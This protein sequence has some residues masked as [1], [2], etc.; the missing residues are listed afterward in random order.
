MIRG[1]MKFIKGIIIMMTIC[2]IMYGCGNKIEEDKINVLFPMEL[3]NNEQELVKLLD[4]SESTVLLNSSFDDNFN[5]CEIIVESYQDGD[6]IKVENAFTF[7]VK[8]SLDLAITMCDV[9]NWDI[10]A[11]SGDTIVS[12]SI[13]AVGESIIDDGMLKAWSYLNYQVDLKLHEPQIIGINYIDDGSTIGHR[14]S[15]Y[16][17]NSIANMYQY[18]YL[19]IL[20]V[21]FE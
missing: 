20:K 8:S 21:K 15:V 1:V 17:D 14:V 4:I 5:K 3:G 2:V 19:Y 7:E 10:K 18:N 13:D 6:L 11:R 9:G 16:E 12:S